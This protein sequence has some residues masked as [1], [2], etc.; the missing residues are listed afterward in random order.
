MKVDE[1]KTIKI[2]RKPIRERTSKER[3][4]VDKKTSQN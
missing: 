2:G 4:K 1:R 3:M